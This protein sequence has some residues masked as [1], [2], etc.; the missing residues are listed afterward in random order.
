MDP[1]ADEVKITDAILEVDGCLFPADIIL[2]EGLAYTKNFPVREDDVFIVTYPKSGTTWMQEI[3]S[4]I[5]NDV[6]ISK[7]ESVPNRNRAPWLE[8]ATAPVYLDGRESPRLAT[9][10]VYATFAPT[11]IMQGK[12]KVVYVYRN[13]KD[14]LI[15]FYHFHNM[16]K[17]LSTPESFESFVSDFMNEKLSFGSWFEHI[18]TWMDVRDKA[19]LMFIA[20]ED[21]HKDLAGSVTHIATF[22]GKKL[23]AEKLKVLVDHCS[24]SSMKNNNMVNYS[25][26][27]STY[28]EKGQKF[29]RKGTVGDW[30]TMFT[31]A[32]N[33]EFD[34]F[35]REKM[36]GYELDDR[37]TS[38]TK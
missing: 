33:E 5:M 34:A 29:M 16:A 2:R 15:S 20:Y 14:T 17:F 38:D 23:D 7:V 6:D 37:W 12:G 13:P 25:E 10:H 32:M 8:L 35:V 28:F 18:K 4:L 31:V 36:K 3:L 22:L 27:P 11:Q 24:F 19:K 26:V 21:L 1:P 9:T 30:K